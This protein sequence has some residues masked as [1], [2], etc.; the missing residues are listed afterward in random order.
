M[1]NSQTLTCFFLVQFPYQS[2]VTDS[3]KVFRRHI[4]HPWGSSCI[5]L[6]LGCEINL[7][8]MDS[9]QAHLS[10]GRLIQIPHRV[11]KL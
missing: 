9:H 8:F 3:F 4:L 6:F 2:K 7:S 10:L 1:Q 11:T 5:L